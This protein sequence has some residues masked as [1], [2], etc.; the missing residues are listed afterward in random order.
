MK[1]QQWHIRDN[2]IYQNSLV[3]TWWSWWYRRLFL[4]KF[5]LTDLHHGRH[6]HYNIVQLSLYFKTTHGPRKCGLILQVVLKQSSLPFGTK[7]SSLIIKGGLKIEGCKIEGLLYSTSVQCRNMTLTLEVIHHR[8]QIVSVQLTPD[9][10]WIDTVWQQD[11]VTVTSRQDTMPKLPG[12]VWNHLET[13]Q[14]KLVR[15][16]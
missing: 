7:S 15:T 13:K 11:T 3:N 12:N 14:S 4:T 6:Y 16:C 1:P 2:P 5:S 8:F 10:W 9:M